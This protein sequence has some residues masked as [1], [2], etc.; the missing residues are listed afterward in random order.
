[1]SVRDLP[2]TNRFLDLKEKEK[3]YR[4]HAVALHAAKASINT[5]QPDTPL[6]L[7]VNQRNTAILRNRTIRNM[8]EHDKLIDAARRGQPLPHFAHKT[9]VTP[10]RRRPTTVKAAELVEYNIFKKDY[11]PIRPKTDR[12]KNRPPIYS[13]DIPDPTYTS[14][15]LDLSTN[16]DN[17][18]GGDY[19]LPRIP[20]D[21]GSSQT[22]A[23]TNESKVIRKS[24]SS[25][26]SSSESKH[27][28][29]PEKIRIAATGKDEN[30]V[31]VT[32]EKEKQTTVVLDENYS[33]SSSSSV[34]SESDD[35]ANIALGQDALTSTAIKSE[36][37]GPEKTEKVSLKAQMDNLLDDL[38]E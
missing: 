10:N 23:Q 8:D 28:Q 30:V 4:K 38:V 1:M 9:S 18:Y 22:K 35:D 25:S 32:E 36:D 19:Y 14:S 15:G 2:A 24:S 3:A 13:D 21:T 26:S 31:I 17:T 6:R 16:N 11:D 5:T 20:I 29:D 34:T 12:R 33:S 7:R 27:T 37:T